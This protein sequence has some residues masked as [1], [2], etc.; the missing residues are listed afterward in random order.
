STDQ[1]EALR[2]LE[3]THEAALAALDRV[4]SELEILQARA[5]MD[6][7]DPTPDEVR[8]GLAARQLRLFRSFSEDPR[9]W[10]DDLAPLL[11]RSLAESRILVAWLLRRDD[12]QLYARFKEYGLGKR[13]LFKL[14]L[15]NW[16][17]DNGGSTADGERL[18]ELER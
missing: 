6:L 10:S 12:A 11:G 7:Y 8:L 18:R 13:K 17:D 9:L 3:A 14:H 2:D 15:E 16:L 5:S 1:H 4:S